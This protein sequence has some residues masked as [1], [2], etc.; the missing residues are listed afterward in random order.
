[1]NRK[2]IIMIIGP[3]AIGKSEFAINKAKEVDAE[4]ISADAFQVYK[5]MNI[6]TAKV[7]LKDQESVPH[8]L[9]DILEPNE[10]YSVVDF[11]KRANKIIQDCRSRNKPIIICGG[12]GFYLFSFLYGFNFQTDIS[13]TDYRERL[14]IAEKE[15]GK[16]Y[17]WEKLN[18]VDPDLAN[19]I[20]FQNSRRVIRALDVYQQSN[21]KPSELQTRNPQP[22]HDVKVIGLTAE[23]NVIYTKINPTT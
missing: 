17:L 8:H 5:E 13:N 3:T 12:T 15:K 9:I 23:R 2:D 10:P 7:E 4:I 14:E 6:G 21:I 16:K 22:R 19:K 20:P 1:M 11:I 18:K